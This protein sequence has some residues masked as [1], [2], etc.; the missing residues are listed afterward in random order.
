MDAHENFGKQ[1][2][3]KSYISRFIKPIIKFS[4]VTLELFISKMCDAIIVVHKDLNPVLSQHKLCK[5]ISNAPLLDYKFEFKKRKKQFCYIGLIS[6]ERGVLHLAQIL[7]KMNF[8]LI[9]AGKFSNNKTKEK[10]LSYKN[11]EFLGWIN[12]NEKKNLIS[13]SIAGCCTFLPIEHHLI[14]NPNKIYEYLNYGTPVLCSDFESY[15]EIIPPNYNFIHYCNI[16][17]KEK[18]STTIKKI[19]NMSD[20]EINSAGLDGHNYIIK[21]YNWEIEGK[22]LLNLYS[23]LTR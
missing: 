12:S 9:L 20:N 2:E 7:N 16:L 3:T 6:E 14:S 17:E 11:V 13:E 8:K 15:K 4:V 23:E 21:N 1:L 18:T 10:I 5:V 22:K 19:T